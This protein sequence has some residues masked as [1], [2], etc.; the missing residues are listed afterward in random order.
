[1][2]MMPRIPNW[3][4]KLTGGLRVFAKKARQ[5]V[6]S[7]SGLCVV[8]APDRSPHTDL[9]VGRAMERAWLE[10][11]ARGLA[12]QPMMSLPVLANVL[13]NGSPEFVASLGPDRIQGLIDD[14]KRLVPE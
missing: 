8:V 11:T 5:L 9:T 14:F 12:A 4:L 1:L 6:E 10:L 3:L 13:D 2:R 7:A